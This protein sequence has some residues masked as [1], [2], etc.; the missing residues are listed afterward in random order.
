[1]ESKIIICIDGYESEF[2]VPDIACQ[3]I[4]VVLD[5]YMECMD[6]IDEENESIIGIVLGDQEVAFNYL[7]IVMA[8]AIAVIASEYEQMYVGITEYKEEIADLA[9]EIKDRAYAEDDEEDEE[10]DE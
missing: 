8:K 7:P 6:F 5:Q 9:E 1:M 2:K 4:A 3:S 10:E